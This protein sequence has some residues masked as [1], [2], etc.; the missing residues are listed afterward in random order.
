MVHALMAFAARGKPGKYKRYVSYKEKWLKQAGD[1][2]RLLRVSGLPELEARLQMLVADGPIRTCASNARKIQGCLGW[3][4]DVLEKG[5]VVIAEIETQ[6]TKTMQDN[7]RRV[8]EA[9]SALEKA[10]LHV[11]DEQSGKMRSALYMDV[12]EAINMKRSA[13]EIKK[14]QTVI[15]KSYRQTI[16]EEFSMNMAVF[17]EELRT[18]QGLLN[19]QLGVLRDTSILGPTSINLD[20]VFRRLEV[21]FND[22]LKE[23]G[24]V[25]EDV[26]SVVLAALSNLVIG[27]V[28]AVIKVYRLIRKWFFKDPERRANEAIAEAN[29]KIGKQVD[30]FREKAKIVVKKLTAEQ[31]SEIQTLLD[32]SEQIGRRIGE[33]ATDV[34]KVMSELEFARGRI[35]T[36]LCG[37]LCPG[38]VKY[39]G[40]DPA[41]TRLV[42]IGEVDADRIA[43]IVGAEQVYAFPSESHARKSVKDEATARAVKLIEVLE[44]EAERVKHEV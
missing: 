26:G 18:I 40:A 13:E 8:V 43:G 33:F 35:L 37:I 5:R 29:E 42:I 21:R 44:T 20:E 34:G 17:L 12:H 23:V 36:A 16:K 19:A 22:V 3:S 31:K 27:I 6:A 25:V 24:R 1:R 38:H 11:I 41:L 39:A 9:C 10:L 4:F 15:L 7:N 2:A 32:G 28:M 30:D 14:S